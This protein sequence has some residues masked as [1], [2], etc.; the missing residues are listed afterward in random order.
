MS[1]HPDVQALVD[2]IVGTWAG[3]GEGGYPTID[4]FEY[5][6]ET[7]LVSR[8]DHPALH[9]EQR[10]W[11]VTP[12]GEEVS[13]WETGLLRISSDGSARLSNAQG[14]RSETMAGTW[15]STGSAWVIRLNSI[16]YSGDDRVIASTRTI[17][18]GN[19]TLSYELDM[20]TTATGEM[21]LHLSGRLERQPTV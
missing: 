11:E 14:G 10:T 18:I 21:T 6:E 1:R 2:A 3:H 12:D 16:G 7:T 9:Y 20:E 13:H 17:E 8:P 19:G 5:R 15:E 4:S